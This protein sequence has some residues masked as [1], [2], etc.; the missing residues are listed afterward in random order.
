MSAKKTSHSRSTAQVPAAHTTTKA[1]T[2][3]RD[4]TFCKDIPFQDGSHMT[5][6]TTG[7]AINPCESDNWT[8]PPDSPLGP[9]PLPVHHPD[10][11]VCRLQC[12]DRY[13]R[14]S[15]SIDLRCVDGAWRD[16][17]K[18]VPGPDWG[19]CLDPAKGGMFCS[20]ASGGRDVMVGALSMK[21]FL[22]IIGGLLGMLLLFGC[23]FKCCRKPR[24][25]R[26]E[27]LQNGGMNDYAE[28]LI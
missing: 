16:P 22:E 9:R 7:D 27:R 13:V 23:W 21:Q 18:C 25:R 17:L 10:G 5:L 3:A 15:G 2:Q 1:H 24:S 8:P 26:R 4:S 12:E 19:K 14:A 6:N 28:V 11:T 20:G